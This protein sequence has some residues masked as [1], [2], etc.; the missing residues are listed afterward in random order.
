[1]HIIWHKLAK[2]LC[3]CAD[4][5]HVWRSIFQISTLKNKKI[6]FLSIFSPTIPILTTNWIEFRPRMRRVINYSRKNAIPEFERFVYN[7]FFC[8]RRLRM[9][10][11]TQNVHKFDAKR[12][13]A[14]FL[15]AV[16][17]VACVCVRIRVIVVNYSKIIPR[18]LMLRD[19]VYFKVSIFMFSHENYCS[20]SV[21]GTFWTVFERHFFHAGF[22]WNKRLKFF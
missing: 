5:G 21:W 19:I 16:M 15:I 9:F 22:A 13:V 1:M 17:N 8:A 3:A 4:G 12:S 7:G 20:F 2:L 10:R 6:H 11:E 14:I 18:C